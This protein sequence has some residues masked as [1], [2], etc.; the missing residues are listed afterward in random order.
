M[1]KIIYCLF[2]TLLMAAFSVPMMAQS[3]DYNDKADD[4]HNINIVIPEITLLDIE[5]ERSTVTLTLGYSTS[6][7]GEAGLAPDATTQDKELW[8]NYTSL[9]ASKTRKVTVALTAGAVPTGMKLLV[10]PGAITTGAGTRGTPVSDV[11]I[12]GTAVDVITGIG[13]CYTDDGTGKGSKLTYK[14]EVGDWTT[15]V[16]ANVTGLTV[17]YTL[18]D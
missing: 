2:G 17:T 16:P 6:S 12:T 8:L 13:S 9:S 7:G 5:P 18:T 10:T 11:E 3:A 14:L 4:T 1:K 15:V